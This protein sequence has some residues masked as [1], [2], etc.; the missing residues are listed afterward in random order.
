MAQ[1]LT[2]DQQRTHQESVAAFTVD[3]LL[4]FA[5][6]VSA[7]L[8]RPRQLN[9]TMRVGVQNTRE[10]LHSGGEQFRLLSARC[11]QD[12]RTNLPTIWLRLAPMQV[13]E[14][15]YVEVEAAFSKEFEFYFDGGQRQDFTGLV[16]QLMA[17]IHKESGRTYRELMDAALD[18]E[19]KRLLAE[20]LQS[21]DQF[22]SW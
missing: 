6:L 11:S 7:K 19:R 14:Y 17:Q 15:R 3:V 1:Q 16:D 12:T 18:A 2:P 13:Q 22:G 10:V 21:H 8:T 20:Q 9:A 5:G 4:A